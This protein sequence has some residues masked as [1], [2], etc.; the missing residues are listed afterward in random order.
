MDNHERSTLEQILAML[1]GLIGRDDAK[2]D[3]RPDLS[4]VSD[5][6]DS[7][8]T[9]TLIFPS[10][11]FAEPEN[12]K[13]P[14]ASAEGT[15]KEK[16]DE[17]R[18]EG[19]FL[20]F[21]D[22][23]LQKMASYFKKDYL[24]HA[25]EVAHI[26]QKENGTFEIRYRRNGRDISRSG[27]TIEI[28]KA[29]FMAAL[30]TP[31]EKQRKKKVR[32]SQ[33]T[34][35]WMAS[36]KKNETK[37]ITYTS[38]LLVLNHYAFPY[39]GK[40]EMKE[41]HP[42]L[43]QNFMNE[44]IEHDTYRTAE[45]LFSILKQVFDFAVAEDVIPKS[46]MAPLRKPRY[47][48]Q[49]GTALTKEEEKTFILRCLRGGKFGIAYLIILYTGIRRAEYQTIELSEE[50]ITVVT[51]KSRRGLPAKKR[52]IPITPMLRKYLNLLDGGLPVI[53]L[54]K[55]THRFPDFA[56]GHHLHELRHTFI[57]RAQ[58]CGIPRELVSLWAGH[59]ADN[60]MTPNVYTHFSDEF[61]LSEAKKF[62]YE[63]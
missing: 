48:K 47:E 26:R 54:D 57:T 13:R 11:I 41:I 30:V 18:R 61:Q 42:M 35:N 12:E 62:L 29:R 25:G 10:R 4:F 33:Y 24:I 1:H 52:R 53:S 9:E 19:R 31:T 49:N 3:F 50:W 21:T 59:R 7:S 20:K 63:V 15:E 2:D 34:L 60:T 44:L 51:A 8:G 16:P 38:Y 58:E 43:V 28:A 17:D 22:K 32:F 6:P 39:F 45:L 5:R 40:T 55:L 27:K 36:V 46:P 56:P 37:P 23:E 14:P